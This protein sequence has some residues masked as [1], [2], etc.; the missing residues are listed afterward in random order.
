MMTTAWAAVLGDLIWAGVLVYAI[1]TVQSAWTH[2]A[3]ES[4]MPLVEETAIPEDLMALAMSQTEAWAQEDLLR[5]VREKYED[6]RDW[7]RVRAAMNIGR[8][9]G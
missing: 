3:G 8:I 2:R 6:L 9:D 7:N 1:R 4:I 5:V